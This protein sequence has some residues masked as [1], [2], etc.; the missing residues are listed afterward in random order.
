[1][2]F[3][4]ISFLQIRR[5]LGAWYFFKISFQQMGRSYGA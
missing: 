4:K 1:L 5:S 3:F 2:V